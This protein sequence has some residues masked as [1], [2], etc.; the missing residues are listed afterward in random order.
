MN[1]RTRFASLSAL[2][3]LAYDMEGHG[4][5][6]VLIHAA[7]ADRRMWDDQ[8]ASFSRSHRVTR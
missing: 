7:I 2:T 4:Q 6:V 1:S 8:M 5:D 3:R